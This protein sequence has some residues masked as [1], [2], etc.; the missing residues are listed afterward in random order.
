MFG[1]S[2]TNDSPKPAE[3]ERA[4]PAAAP[5][6]STGFIPP[7]SGGAPAMMGGNPPPQRPTPVATPSRS[8]PPAGS[9]IIGPDLHIA[10]DKI[11]IT[12]ESRLQVD[13]QIRGD[14]SGR[15][16]VIGET[17]SV[18]GTVSADTIEV[19][20]RVEGA[21]RGAS[22]SLLPTSRVDGDV[23]HKTLTIAEG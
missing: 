18:T 13:G 5:M 6:A 4:A 22:V 11:I 15:E 3:P 12:C 19:R 16:I 23:V 17:G 8:S 7:T 1:R 9:S 10:G 14:L 21:I 2:S 20:G